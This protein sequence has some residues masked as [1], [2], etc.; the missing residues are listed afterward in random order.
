MSK[1]VIIGGGTMGADIAAIFVAHGRDVEVVES[2]S[3]ARETLHSRIDLAVIEMAQAGA[4]G[5]VVVRQ[6]VKDVDWTGADIVIEC[7]SEALPVKQAVFAELERY[8]PAE[9]PLA[10][11]SSGLPITRISEGLSTGRRMLGLHFFMPGHL[12]PAVEVIRGERT[13]PDVIEKAYAIMAALDKKPVRVQRDVPGF[14]ANRIQHAMMR[15][16]ISLVEQGF[17]SAEDVDTVVRYGFGLRYV[18]A[19]PL[20]QKDLAGIDIHCAAAASMYPY[21]CTDAAPSPLMQRLVDEG[22]IGVKARQGFYQWN[23]ADI[24]QTRKRYKADLVKALAILKA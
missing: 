4:R 1:G 7:V 22:K 20:L 9:L 21:L 6:A 5:G 3:S 14:L 8:A 2:S 17:A 23:D 15:E 12:V 11:N 16:A 13:D 10:S 24:E 18:A 19:G